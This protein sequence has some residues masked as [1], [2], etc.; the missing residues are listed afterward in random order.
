MKL[1]ARRVQRKLQREWEKFTLLH[2]DSRTGFLSYSRDGGK[3]Y[4]ID[5]RHYR[6]QCEEREIFEDIYYKYYGRRGNDVVVDIGAG[7][8][9]EAAY[10]AKQSPSVKYIAVEIQPRVFEC[11]SNTL[12]G[13][14]PNFRAFPLAVA[15]GREVAIDSSIDY[16]AVGAGAAVVIPAIS[17]EDLLRRFEVSEV[18]LLK[19]N[20]E[21]GEVD[22]LGSIADF[23]RIRRVVVGCHDH[24]AN[25]GDG[26]YF[27]TRARVEALLDPIYPVKKT[28]SSNE[29]WAEGYLF[30]S[31]DLADG[32]R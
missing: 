17:W 2:E 6:L 26:E 16:H 31:N 4:L 3:I 15:E 22:F 19:I 18:A 11:L 25:R 20:I 9:Q 30:Y 28:F 14:G 21:G 10:L 8:G 24:R 27:R 1:T 29:E 12:H 32:G 5:R 13:I 23:G 7:Y